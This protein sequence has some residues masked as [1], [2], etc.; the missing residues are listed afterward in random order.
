MQFSSRHKGNA[1]DGGGPRRHSK[2]GQRQ[3]QRQRQLSRCSGTIQAKFTEGRGVPVPAQ[4]V[5]MP[6]SGP[7]LVA[8]VPIMWLPYRLPSIK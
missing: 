5:R 3:C 7:Y 1:K 6:V 2:S 8:A 4:T